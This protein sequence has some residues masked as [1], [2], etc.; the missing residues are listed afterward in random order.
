MSQ[1]IIECGSGNTCRNEPDIVRAMI[2]TI[3][4][5]DTGKHEIVFKWQLFNKAPPNI[6]L[7]RTIFSFAHSYAASKGYKTTASVF[8]KSSLRYLLAFDIPFVKIANRPDLYWLRGEIPRRFPIYTS[9]SLDTWPDYKYNTWAD[10]NLCCIS[11][12]PAKVQDYEAF[13]YYDLGQGISD[14]T[15]GLDLWYKYQPV[16]WEKHLVFE[17]DKDNPD[18]GPFAVTPGELKEIL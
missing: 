14:H 13:D 8:D 3:A 9:M 2:N 12:Y 6:P 15:V 7:T 5:I 17:H 16:I 10:R 4:I 1:I 18:A 11:K